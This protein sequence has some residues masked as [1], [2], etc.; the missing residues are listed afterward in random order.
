M[1]ER[2]WKFYFPF[3]LRH[4]QLFTFVAKQRFT[5][6]SNQHVASVFLAPSNHSAHHKVE[7]C[8]QIFALHKKRLIIEC[9]ELFPSLI[10]FSVW[11]QQVELPER[12]LL[13]LLKLNDGKF[14]F[15]A[16]VIEFSFQFAF[17]RLSFVAAQSNNRKRLFTTPNVPVFCENLL[18]KQLRNSLIFSVF[19]RFMFLLNDP[20]EK[21]SKLS[22]NTVK[23]FGEHND[24]R[25]RE[26]CLL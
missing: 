5:V 11:K 1:F 12:R 10:K 20:G 15:H 23:S 13:M 3:S 26:R 19:L 6:N 9:D 8:F 14:C 22:F 24:S 25:I 18:L 21:R 2:G 17:Q 16:N 4:R 7:N